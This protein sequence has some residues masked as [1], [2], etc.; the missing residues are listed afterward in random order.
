VVASAVGGTTEL[1]R[2]G[3]HGLLFP[4]TDDAALACTLQRLLEAPA[5]LQR[6]RAAVPGFI[7]D[8]DWP[9]VAAR[10]LELYRALVCLPPHTP[11]AASGDRPAPAT[12]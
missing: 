3:A 5:F 12:P 9:M 6:L 4:S 7:R 8:F 1:V 11:P 10:Y 2:D